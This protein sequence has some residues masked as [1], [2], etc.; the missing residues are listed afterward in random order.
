[1]AIL[2][3]QTYGAHTTFADY[4]EYTLFMLPAVQDIEQIPTRGVR[5]DDQHIAIVLESSEF[6]K[7]QLTTNWQGEFDKNGMTRAS[8]VPLGHAAKAYK[9]VGDRDIDGKVLREGEEGWYYLWHRG[10]QMLG[11][12]ESLDANIYRQRPSFEKD[13]YTG[14]T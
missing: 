3:R 4:D 10:L 2:S 14:I 1:M 5:L 11:G 13:L 12:Q 8:R 6:S 9:N 7:K